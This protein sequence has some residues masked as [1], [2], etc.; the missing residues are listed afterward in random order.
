M[1]IPEDAQKIPG[2]ID[3]IASDIVHADYSKNDDEPEW[4]LYKAIARAILAERERCAAIA[5]E[6]RCRVS[7]GIYADVEVD[8]I[9]DTIGPNIAHAIRSASQP[10]NQT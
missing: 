7:G 1:G 8:R 10:T 9:C 5:D 2:D 3:R 6:W 4:L